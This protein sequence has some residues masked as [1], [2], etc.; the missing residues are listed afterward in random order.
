[1]IGDNY[2]GKTSLIFSYAKDEFPDKYLTTV[3][4]EY[5]VSDITYQREKITLSV[6]DLSAQDDH[7][8]LREFAYSKADAVIYCFT[9]AD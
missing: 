6:W 5:E 1:M 9:L 2:A 4:D 3:A 7:I 8:S